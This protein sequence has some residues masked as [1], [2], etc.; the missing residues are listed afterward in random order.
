MAR[1]DHVDGVVGDDDIRVSGCVIEKLF[2]LLNCLFRW[3]LLV[4]GNGAECREHRWINCPCVV[5]E[6]TCHFLNEFLIFWGARWGRVSVFGV[7]SCLTIYWFDMWVGLVLG[8]ARVGVVK[9][10]ESGCDV[11]EHGQVN[12]AV[13]LVPV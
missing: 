10:F 13:F 2:H 8:F 9:A 7:L 4:G 6:S 3:D 1:Q 5:K 11:C 12:F